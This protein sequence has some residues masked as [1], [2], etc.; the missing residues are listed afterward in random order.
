MDSMVTIEAPARLDGLNSG[1]FTKF[2]IGLLDAGVRKIVLDLSALNYMSSAGVRTFMLIRKET[3]ARQGKL[4][5][6]FCRPTI[7]DV[8]RMCGLT[9]LAPFAESVEAAKLHVR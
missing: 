3:A 9:D 5:F 8:L 2:V 1:D 4:V 6:L 7:R